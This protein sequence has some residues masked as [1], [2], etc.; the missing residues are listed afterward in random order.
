MSL[1]YFLSDWFAGVPTLGVLFKRFMINVAWA[2][3]LLFVM[4]ILQLPAEYAAVVYFGVLVANCVMGI[5]FAFQ[6]AQ[7]R[8]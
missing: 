7:M 2:C 5:V 4:I 1:W 6:R 3:I 8:D